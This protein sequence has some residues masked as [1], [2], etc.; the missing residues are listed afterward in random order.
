MAKTVVSRFCNALSHGALSACAA[1]L[2]V[3]VHHNT[4]HA[5][6]S[7]PFFDALTVAGPVGCGLGCFLSETTY[8]AL[9]RGESP[10]ADGVERTSNPS[11]RGQSRLER[12]PP[13]HWRFLSRCTV[14]RKR[15]RRAE[16]LLTAKLRR[17]SRLG[18]DVLPAARKRLLSVQNGLGAERPV[19]EAAIDREV[20]CGRC[21]AEMAERAAAAGS[22]AA[23]SFPGAAAK[24]SGKTLRACSSDA[25][26]RWR[27]VPPRRRVNRSVD[28]PD[29]MRGFTWSGRGYEA[30]TG[31]VVRPAWSS[32]PGQ[33]S[34]EPTPPRKDD[35]EHE[36]LSLLDEHRIADSIEEY[37][38]P[39][40]S[41]PTGWAGC[42]RDWSRATTDHQP[43]CAVRLIGVPTIRLEAR[44]DGVFGSGPALRLFRADDQLCRGCEAGR[45]RRPRA[46][47]TA[48]VFLFQ[49]GQLA[50]LR[51]QDLRSL[52]A[53]E[54]QQ[55]PDWL[56]EFSSAARRELWQ[57]AYSGGTIGQAA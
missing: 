48:G 3:F 8:R 12:L 56:F 30:I 14:C 18:D 32:E 22:H 2:E 34:H 36:V 42:L 1:P 43:A 49:L 40:A 29:R 5:F 15:R 28:E 27:R 10:N 57:K 13:K 53:G 25:D 20:C 52:G 47:R 50:G 17:L 9:A 41:A 6:Q 24:L 46:A 21:A 54:T 19:S 11:W 35:A 37:V 33:R 7:L 4:L 55:Q 23:H 16:W 44:Y 39:D 38:A 51:P 45:R 31:L 26:S